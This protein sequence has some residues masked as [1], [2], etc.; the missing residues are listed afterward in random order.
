M[1]EAR[2]WPGRIQLTMAYMNMPPM[3]STSTAPEAMI[4]GSTIHCAE[5]SMPLPSFW[6]FLPNSI[7]SLAGCQLESLGQPQ[8]TEGGLHQGETLKAWQLGDLR[9]DLAHLFQAVFP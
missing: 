7:G 3:P 2:E 5:K 4:R 1:L 8:L 9:V 6:L